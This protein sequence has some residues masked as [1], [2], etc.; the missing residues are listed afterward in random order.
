MNNEMIIREEG[1]V[2]TLQTQ[3]GELASELNGL[4]LGRD[5][6]AI[7]AAASY[8]AKMREF[9]TPEIMKTYIMPLMNTKIGFLTDKTKGSDRYSVDIV[10][11]CLIDAIAFGLQPTQNQFNILAGK[12]YPTKEGYSS[13]LKSN[14]IKYLID[15]GKDEPQ[16]TDTVRFPVSIKYSV[17]NNDGN[18]DL[19]IYVKKDSYSSLDALRGKAER[20]AKK[21][22]YEYIMGID[23]GEGD[24]FSTG[25]TPSWAAQVSEYAEIDEATKIGILQYLEQN[26]IEIADFLSAMNCESM[27]DLVKKDVQRARKIAKELKHNKESFKAIHA[28]IL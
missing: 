21:Q 3:F 17:E 2:A 9:L 12:M 26:N 27:S 24:E 15:I 1:S 6:V 19:N 10:R 13:L 14:G 7:F 16:G 23:L 18:I 28:E 22:L 20:K 25:A 5:M 4:Q 11:D 8:V